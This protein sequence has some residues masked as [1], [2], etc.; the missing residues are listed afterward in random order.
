M[1]AIKEI[2]KTIQG[3]G[4]QAGRTAVFVRF[5]GCNLWTGRE[6]HRESAVCQFCDTDFVG[7]DGVNGGSYSA[8]K[9]L[10]K[11]E[12]IW[13]E[14]ENRLIVFT[15]GE[16]MLQLDRVLAEQCK[17]LGFE[18][19]IETNGTIAIEFDIDWVCVSPKHGSELVVKEGNELKVVFPQLGQNL[20]DFLSL[21]FDHL[22]L[23]PMD[24]NDGQ[25]NTVKTI[26]Y[27][28]ENPKWKLS[29]QQH[30]LIGMP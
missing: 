7:T 30:K 17:K 13:G 29:I 9:L 5:S 27:C 26:Q 19:A 24:G 28:L 8:T 15:G 1:Y 21:S 14:T 25:E 20:D 10:E 23:Q 3:E 6:K 2:Y 18:I 11:I 12:L 22:F 4:A 16:P